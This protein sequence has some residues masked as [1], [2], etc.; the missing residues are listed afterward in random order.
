VAL[1]KASA[2]K[3]ALLAISVVIGVVLSVLGCFFAFQASAVDGPSNVVLQVAPFLLT[4]SA[5]AAGILLIAPLR[6]ISARSD[7]WL[8]GGSLGLAFASLAVLWTVPI[9]LEQLARDSPN[10]AGH[11]VL[12]VTVAGFAGSAVL[13]LVLMRVQGGKASRGPSNK[14]IERTPR[15]LS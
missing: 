4:A 15:A 7:L 3:G 6:A 5:V 13:S 9:W 1:K 14:R 8:A 11:L 12:Y 2:G 10:D